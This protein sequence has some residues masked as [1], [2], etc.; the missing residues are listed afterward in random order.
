MITRDTC[1]ARLAPLRDA[2]EM[3]GTV[4]ERS[5]AVLDAGYRRPDIRRLSRPGDRRRGVAAPA[6]RDKPV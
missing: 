1:G 5:R 2:V 6:S 3:T 4:P